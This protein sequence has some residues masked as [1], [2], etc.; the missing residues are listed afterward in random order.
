MRALPFVLA[1]SAAAFALGTAVSQRPDAGGGTGPFGPLRVGDK[2]TM[3]EKQGRYEF[4][5]LPKLDGGSHTVVE[6]ARDHIAV[7]DIAGVNRTWIPV[8]SVQAVTRFQLG[9]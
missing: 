2:V 3:R 9:R 6:L 1:V 7:E 5:L 8:T 4:T